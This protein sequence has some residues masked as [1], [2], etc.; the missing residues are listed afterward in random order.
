MAYDLD[1]QL[2]LKE[3]SSGYGTNHRDRGEKYLVDRG[4]A[5]YFILP[6]GEFYRWGKSIGNSILEE[7]LIS[8]YYAAPRLLHDARAVV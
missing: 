1:Q 5:W 4:G 2:G 6:N 8:V 7:T 3:P